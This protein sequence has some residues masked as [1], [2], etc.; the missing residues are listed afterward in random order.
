MLMYNISMG[1]ILEEEQKGFTIIEVM[2]FLA[3]SGF[4][5]VGI[6][7]GTGSSIANQRYK[8]AVQDAADALRKAYSFVADTE[9]STRD[10]NESVC[11]YKDL[12]S[13]EAG[14]G[15]SSCAVYGAVVVINRDTIQTTTL[16]GKDYYD[17]LVG[18]DHKESGWDDSDYTK[19]HQSSA[20]D[21]D[22]LNVL[23]ANNLARLCSDDTGIN[24]TTA[25]AGHQTTQKLKWG[26]IFKKPNSGEEKNQ[27]LALTLLIYRSPRDGS[28]R[29]LV[30][31]DVLRDELN[32]PINYDSID[33]NADPKKLGVFR[34][35]KQNED[36]TNNDKFSQKNVFFCIDSGGGD[37]YADHARIIR[38]V[39]NA[40]S[41]SGIKLEDLDA[42][43]INPDT[44]E[45]VSCDKE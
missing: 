22:I 44:G 45:P 41:Q 18:V 10:K 34:Y 36:G 26:A 5:L 13:S 7:A 4:L 28:I 19:I 24:C 42:E 3:L 16:I 40:H 37:S 27:D 12:D 32:N 17:M 25:V 33:A 9:I 1:I 6:L 20:T 15:R 2:L 29:T 35:I 8:D 21:L 38:I 31:D 23:E 39:K 14:R 30:Y 43:I 11:K